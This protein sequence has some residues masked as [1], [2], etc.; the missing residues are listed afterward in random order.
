MKG[1]NLTHSLARSQNKGMSEYQRRAIQVCTDPSTQL[2]AERQ[3]CHSQSQ[4]AR[5]NLGL[6]PAS[7]TKLWAGSQLLTTSSWDTGWLTSAK[8]V[9]AWDQLCWGDTWHDWD[10]ALLAHPGN[11]V[12]GSREVIKMLGPP[13]IVLLPNTWSPELLGPGRAQNT[14]PIDSALA[15][16]LK[17]ST[18]AA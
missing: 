5:G 1:S 16:Y 11:W 8:R 3:V 12:A 4:K 2:E 18:W 17:S 15:E 10:S 14:C 9:A 13:G 6:R 7:S